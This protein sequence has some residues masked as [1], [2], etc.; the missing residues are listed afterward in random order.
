MA[1]MTATHL[2]LST[3]LKCSSGIWTGETASWG[4]RFAV[5]GGGGTA[6][7]EDRPALDAGQITLN[8]FDCHT[9]VKTRSLTT[10][11]IPGSVYQSWQGDSSPDSEQVTENDI[12]FFITKATDFWVAVK[13]NIPSTFQL[14]SIKLYAVKADGKAPLGPNEWRP[15]GSEPGSVSTGLHSPELA[16][17][18]SL[19]TAHRHKQGRGRFYVGPLGNALSSTDGLIATTFKNNLGTAAKALQD[20]VRTRGTPGAS[21]TYAGIV[22]NRSPGTTGAVINKIR[23]GDEPDRQERRTKKRPET[24]VDYAVV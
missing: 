3:N 23:L 19:Y 10:S 16:F 6:P 9:D 18:V 8:T 11:S 21:A 14:S 22:W 15:T 12:D 1:T 13:P 20:S 17:A 5:N 7:F 24:F 2:L 4:L